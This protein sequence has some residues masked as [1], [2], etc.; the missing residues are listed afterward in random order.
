MSTSSGPQ[1]STWMTSSSFD[2]IASS[3]AS[4]WPSSLLGSPCVGSLSLPSSAF[5]TSSSHC[6]VTSSNTMSTSS[7]PQ[8]STWMTSS[9]TDSTASSCASSWPSFLLGSPFVGSFSSYSP[10][11]CSG[12]GS[13]AE[14]SSCDSLIA[15]SSPDTSE[16]AISSSCLTSA[17][18]FLA[19]SPLS[20]SSAFSPPG[21]FVG[22]IST[23]ALAS[24]GSS[25]ASLAFVASSACLFA[26]R[27]FWFIATRVSFIFAKTSSIAALRSSV[28][29]KYLVVF[30]CALRLSRTLKYA[31]YAVHKRCCLASLSLSLGS[32]AS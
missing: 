15:S 22:P 25:L 4:S 10:S 6:P 1:S 8:S 14:S 32:H 2:A 21:A 23:S 27:D 9:T 20:V 16:G 29:P 18:F 24:A 30:V 5:R 19:S 26:R 13:S 31:L 12:A 11:A 7:G 3:C 28:S 17:G